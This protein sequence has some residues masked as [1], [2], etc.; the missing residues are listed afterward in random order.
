MSA[1]FLKRAFHTPA[2]HE[3]ENDRKTC[4]LLIGA[5]KRLGFFLAAGIAGENPADRQRWL[6]KAIP[7][8]RPRTPLHLLLA[9]PIPRDLILLPVDGRVSENLIEFGQSFA[10]HLGLASLAA[11]FDRRRRFSQDTIKLA[12][13]DHG[14][15]TMH[16]V[17]PQLQTVISP[18]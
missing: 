9:L 14:H 15:V 1:S 12:W 5:E 18:I 11:Q 4:T 10:D 8:S 3:S 17:N 2:H 7:Q 16:C 13:G 6:S